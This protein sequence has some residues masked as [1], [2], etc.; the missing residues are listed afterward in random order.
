MPPAAR[1]RAAGR[2]DGAPGSAGGSDRGRPACGAE[3]ASEGAAG[4]GAGAVAEGPPGAQGVAAGGGMPPTPERPA[5]RARAAPDQAGAPAA[6]VGSPVR[7]CEPPDSTAAACGVAQAGAARCAASAEAGHA[8]DGR[9]ASAGR[10]PAPD[11]PQMD[12]RWGD[13]APPGPAGAGG[14][15]CARG[16]KR[17]CARAPA[18]SGA[19][20]PGE[21]LRA[22]GCGDV[23]TWVACD[24]CDQW[25]VLPAG[26]PV[27]PLARPLPMCA[28]LASRGPADSAALSCAPARLKRAGPSIMIRAE[29]V[30]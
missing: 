13:G 14:D 17:G 29:G 26:H 3:P 6:G 2:E 15:A 16:G 11:A 18:S 22:P 9:A 4:W 1:P 5:K 12:V 27:G 30:V 28:A 8:G 7:D 10:A 24:L 19:A 25:R 23:R 20:P 21:R